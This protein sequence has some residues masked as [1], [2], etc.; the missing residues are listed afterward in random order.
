MITYN[1]CTKHEKL[2]TARVKRQNNK[3]FAQMPTKLSTYDI[4]PQNYQT[5]EMSRGPYT[6][7]DSP[8]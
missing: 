3:S 7:A 1:L 6:F 8:T 4:T 2:V 5:E